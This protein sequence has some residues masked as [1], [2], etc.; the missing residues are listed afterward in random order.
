VSRTGKSSCTRYILERDELVLSIRTPLD[1]KEQRLALV[2]A[3]YYTTKMVM[4][5]VVVNHLRST[6]TIFDFILFQILL[7]ESL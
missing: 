5:V 2:W 7:C 1:V 4:I 3:C 6:T